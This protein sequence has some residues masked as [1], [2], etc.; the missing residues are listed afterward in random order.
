MLTSVCNKMVRG[1]KG[2]G[3][4]QMVSLSLIFLLALLC[5]IMVGTSLLG[6][7]IRKNMLPTLSKMLCKNNG[8]FDSWELMLCSEDDFIAKYL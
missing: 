1:K 5:V 7:V 2:K 8:R 3:N 4:C 6:V